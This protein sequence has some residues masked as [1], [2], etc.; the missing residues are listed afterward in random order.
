CW[1]RGEAQPAPLAAG[2]QPRGVRRA[3]RSVRATRGDRRVARGGRREPAARSGWRRRP[4]QLALV[5]QFLAPGSFSVGEMPGTRVRIA[6]RLYVRGF[7][8]FGGFSY[9]RTRDSTGNES[10]RIRKRVAIGIAPLAFAGA[11]YL[12][13]FHLLSKGTHL[14]LVAALDGFADHVLGL[15]LVTHEELP[16]SQLDLPQLYVVAGSRHDERLRLAVEFDHGLGEI[17]AVSLDRGE[18]AAGVG[19]AQD[20]RRIH[21]AEDRR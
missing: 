17:H 21:A 4:S 3:P 10:M 15:R 20:Q 5:G 18:Q 2:E 13:G 1:P 9:S 7:L 12:S 11:I 6:K 19:A 8:W 14:E 16:N